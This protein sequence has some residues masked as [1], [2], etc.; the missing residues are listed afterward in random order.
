M[1][2]GSVLPLKLPLFD[3]RT[4]TYD[5]F[6]GFLSNVATQDIVNEGIF[7]GSYCSRRFFK[8]QLSKKSRSQDYS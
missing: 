8:L 2:S 5:N 7:I 4:L 3:Q 6:G 1:L